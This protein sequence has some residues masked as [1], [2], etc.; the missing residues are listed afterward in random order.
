MGD[1]KTRS[2]EEQVQLEDKSSKLNKSASWCNE[3]L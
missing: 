1:F 3:Y 2:V